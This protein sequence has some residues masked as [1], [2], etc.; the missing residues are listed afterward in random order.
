[1]DGDIAIGTIKRAANEATTLGRE[2]S[3]LREA[4]LELDRYL[5]A[6]DAKTDKQQVQGQ[7]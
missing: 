7:R 2:A 5:A 6:S 4:T 3:K 1:M